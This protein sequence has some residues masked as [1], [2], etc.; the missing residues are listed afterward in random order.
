MTLLHA[1]PGFGKTACLAQWQK[2][3]TASGVRVAWLSIDPDDDDVAAFLGYLAASLNAADGAI[4]AD[5]MELSRG[6]AMPG[7]AALLNPLLNQLA[8][9][10]ICS[11]LVPAPG[12]DPGTFG[13]QNAF[14]P[15]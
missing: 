12:I 6:G 13:L 15:T 10:A 14:V 9:S 3:L 7:S 5:V 1:G 8:A 11:S 4:G 2:A